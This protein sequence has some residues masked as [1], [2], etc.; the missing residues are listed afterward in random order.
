[1][2]K[3]HVTSKMRRIFEKIEMGAVDECWK[4]V[5]THSGKQGDVRPYVTLDG[6]KWLV[7]RLVYNLT[8]GEPLHDDEVMRHTCDNSWCV[9]P[10]H[11]ERGSHQENM[12]DMKER[13]R[14]GLTHHAVKAIKKLLSDGKLTHKEISANF[15][16]S[17][18]TITAINND[19]VYDHVEED[20]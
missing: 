14:H 10:Y 16:V 13:Q 2:T 19:R 9:N 8:H 3:V 15:G 12:N 11:Q 20:H 18:E 7:Y 6:K 4:W 17:R 5:G 1:M